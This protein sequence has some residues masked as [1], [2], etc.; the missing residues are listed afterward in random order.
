MTAQTKPNDPSMEE[1]LSSIRRIIADD[2]A[3]AAQKT[4]PA[5][6]P[7]AE[8]APVSR[9]PAPPPAHDD[10]F[11][12]T[13]ELLAEPAEDYN[14]DDVDLLFREIEEEQQAEQAAMVPEPA[15]PEPI[16]HEP[17]PAPPVM[18]YAPPM[19]PPSPPFM[20]MAS[21]ISP[22]VGASVSGAFSQLAH[23]VLAQNART[24]DDLVQE[25]LKPMLKG[26]LDENLPTVVERLV[27][28]EIER[29]ARGGR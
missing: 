4:E 11:D 3:K 6:A 19:P 16:A 9:A 26:W 15:E 8:M 17:P 10:V 28:A 1:I 7:V 5:P 25:M 12:L 21:L 24:L 20:D 22:Q 14:Q 29:V 18:Q 27:R 2:Q 13:P 23:T